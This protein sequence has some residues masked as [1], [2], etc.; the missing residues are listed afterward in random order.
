MISVADLRRLCP[1]AR[2]DIIAPLAAAMPAVLP[3]YG[4]TTRLRFCHFIAQAAHETM[5]FTTLNELGGSAYFE[6]M[7]GPDT[8]VGRRLGNTQPGDGARY[9]GRGIFQLTG[10]TNYGALGKKVGADLVAEPALAARPDISLRVACEYWRGRNIN[11]AADADDV[12]KVTRAIN[13]GTNG[14]SERKAYLA[15][16][17]GI[18]T[19][20]PLASAP[21]QEPRPAAVEPAPVPAPEA[22]P[23]PPAPASEPIPAAPPLAAP[24]PPPAVPD[25]SM[26]TLPAIATD[27]PPPLT[28]SKTLW[29]NI[30][31]IFSGGGLGFYAN[32]LLQNPN[33]PWILGV[34]GILFVITVIAGAV[35]FR[36][37]IAKRL[38]QGV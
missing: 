11:A 14:L 36:E 23:A 32:E 16:A 17:K 4:I 18:W 25:E 30:T 34:V 15:K 2:E 12:V 9:H 1:K 33:A 29:G 20:D 5:G 26:A 3:A 7:Y 35:V 28:R 19:G 27:A 22:I 24:T 10:R 8:A 13:G 38:E 37:R 31:G 6:K 21:P